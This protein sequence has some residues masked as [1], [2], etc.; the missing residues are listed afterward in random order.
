MAK[1]GRG[2]RAWGAGKGRRA[3]AAARPRGGWGREKRGMG[4]AGEREM[5]NPLH[6]NGG[7]L[8]GEDDLARAEDNFTD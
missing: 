5:K 1:K 8:T 3:A 2:S 7:G 4:Y 6:T